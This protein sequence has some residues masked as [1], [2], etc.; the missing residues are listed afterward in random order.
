MHDPWEQL[1]AVEIPPLPENFT[2]DVHQRLNKTILA[3]HLLELGMGAAAFACRHFAQALMGLVLFTFSG[4]F[5][6]ER[7]IRPPEAP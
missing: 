4:R 1:A 2:G 7:E 6:A 5:E 3:M